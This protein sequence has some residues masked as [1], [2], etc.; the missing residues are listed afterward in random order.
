MNLL[1]MKAINRGNDQKIEVND[2]NFKVIII[3][4]K[5]F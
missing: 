1:V 5:Y 3:L 4:L 2:Q